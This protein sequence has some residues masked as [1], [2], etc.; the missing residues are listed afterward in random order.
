MCLRAILTS[1]SPSIFRGTLLHTGRDRDPSFQLTFLSPEPPSSCRA[2]SR[3]SSWSPPSSFLRMQEKNSSS[4]HHVSSVK[5][6]LLEVKTLDIIVDFFLKEESNVKLNQIWILETEI[7]TY[8][9]CVY[10]SGISRYDLFQFAF[11]IY[12]IFKMC[13]L[14]CQ[15]IFRS[16]F[17]FTGI[18]INMCHI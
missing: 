12:S 10:Y 9:M 5:I 1:P 11:C 7:E 14:Q 17:C 13:F 3:C 2:W 4:T 8:D 15:I 6:S 18:L 16:L